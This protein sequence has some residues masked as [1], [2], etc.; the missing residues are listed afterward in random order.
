MRCHQGK[1]S[2]TALLKPCSVLPSFYIFHP[3]SSTQ[4]LFLSSVSQI[5]LF[6]P[7]FLSSISQPLCKGFSELRASASPKGETWL[8]EHLPAGTQGSV[9]KGTLHTVLDPDLSSSQLFPGDP[10]STLSPSLPSQRC[11]R[12]LCQSHFS[13]TRDREFLHTKTKSFALYPSAKSDQ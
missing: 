11:S 12:L 1:C 5:I 6:L 8:G 10:F 3:L 4:S 7:S 13:D 2:P 9:R